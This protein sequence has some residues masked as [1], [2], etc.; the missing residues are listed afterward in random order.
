MVA[1]MAGATDSKLEVARQAQSGGVQYE[2]LKLTDSQFENAKIKV[3][4][5]KLWNLLEDRRKNGRKS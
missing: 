4:N 3:K 5:A 1:G 2:Q